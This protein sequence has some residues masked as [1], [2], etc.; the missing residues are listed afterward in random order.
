MPLC[1]EH[2]Q[3]LERFNALSALYR[4]AYPSPALDCS[5]PAS[6][7]IMMDEDGSDSSSNGYEADSER[8]SFTSA[9]PALTD[10][11]DPYDDFDLDL[12]F[13]SSKLTFTGESASG[14][15]APVS[16]QVEEL[17]ANFPTAFNALALPSPSKRTAD[18]APSA[19]IEDLLEPANR[20]FKKVR[21]AKTPILTYPQDF[22]RPDS[23]IITTSKTTLKPSSADTSQAPDTIKACLRLDYSKGTYH[24]PV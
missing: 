4:Q 5:P 3:D 17:K 18:W 2:A 13:L 20:P 9:S 19:T 16:S 14:P 10:D 24:T 23:P 7:P 22:V 8:A 21:F 15:L 11:I 1:A 12:G 6:S